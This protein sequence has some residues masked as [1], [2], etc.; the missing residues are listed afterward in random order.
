MKRIVLNL[1]NK[2][3]GLKVFKILNNLFLKNLI[4]YKTSFGG[5]L[6]MVLLQRIYKAKMN[7]RQIIQPFVFPFVM[8][9][10]FMT[11]DRFKVISSS[12]SGLKL[13]FC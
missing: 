11:I 13:T 4:G 10:L 2:P 1:N 8:I 7:K 9:F 5:Q 12:S 6:K 3:F